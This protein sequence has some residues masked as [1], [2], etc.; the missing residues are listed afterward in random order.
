VLGGPSAA[1][2]ND[3]PDVTAKFDVKLL[4]EGGEGTINV[5]AGR[6]IELTAIDDDQDASLTIGQVVSTAGNTSIRADD[7]ILAASASTSFIQGQRVTLVAADGD[8]RGGTAGSSQALRVNSDVLNKGDKGTGGFN[9]I[10]GGSIDVVET[11]GDLR[12]VK[13]GGLVAAPSVV[14]T[15]TVRLTTLAGS[16]LDANKEGTQLVAAGDTLTKAQQYAY[17]KL[18][19]IA[20]IDYV[21]TKDKVGNVIKTAVYDTDPT[22]NVTLASFQFPVAPGLYK[23]LF[24][25]A[26]FVG[27]TP[28]SGV[29]ETMNVIGSKVT[30]VADGGGQ[31]GRGLSPQVVDMTSGF[32]GLSEA[33]KQLLST[34]TVADVYGVQHALYRYVGTGDAGTNLVSKNFASADWQKISYITTGANRDAPVLRSVANGGYVLAEF[35]NG[36]YGLYKFLGSAGTLDLVA[37]NFGN[38][39]RW[40]KVAAQRQTDDTATSALT[41]GTLVLN[42]NVVERIGLQLQDDVD[43]TS[44]QGVILE[45]DGNVSVQTP[46]TMQVERVRAAGSVYLRAGNGIT[47]VGTQPGSAVATF[48]DLVL[49]AD[50][51]SIGGLAKAPMRIQVGAGG[52]LF[53]SA[54]GDIE[55]R[56]VSGTV[57]INSVTKSIGSLYVD[58]VNAGGTLG[59]VVDSGDMTVERADAKLGARLVATTG[60]IKDAFLDDAAPLVN[61]ASGDLYLEAGTTI[62]EA[63]NFLDVQ[64]AGDLSGKAGGSVYINS[65]STLNITTLESKGGDVTLTVQAQTNIGLIQAHLGTV[66]ITSKDAISDRYDE[67]D[68]DIEARSVVLDSQAGTIGTVDNPLDINTSFTGVLGTVN[69]VALSTV[70]LIETAGV[71]R[72]A[73]VSSKTDDVTLQARSGDI[74]DA[75]ADLITNVTARTVNLLAAGG[76]IGATKDALEVDSS[77]PSQGV[78]NAT[79]TQSINVTELGGTLYVGTVKA[80]AGDVILSVRD[81][82]GTGEDLV[83]DSTASISAPAGS[84]F[85]RVG[86]NVQMAE[87]ATITAAAQ[88]EVRTDADDRAAADADVGKGTVSAYYGHLAAKDIFVYGRDDKDD[89]LFTPQSLAGWTR[90]YGGGANDVFTLEQLPTLDVTDKTNGAGPTGLVTGRIG[91]QR[92]TV[93]IDGQSGEDRTTIITSGNTDY[94]VNVRDTGAPNDGADR[95]TIEGGAGNDVFLS[96]RDFVARLQPN[97]FDASGVPTGYKD[98]YERINY[99]ESINGRLTIEGLGGNDRFHADDNGALMTLDGGAGDDY[100]QF[101]QVFG[102]PRVS[103]AILHPDTG[104]PVQPRVAVGDEIDT[105][106]TTLGMLSRGISFPTVVYGGDG[107]DEFVVYSN[108]ALLK[109]FG[110]DGNDEFVV[111]AFI[112]EG[113]DDLASTDTEVS[114]GA[115]DDTVQYNINAPLSID[116]GAGADTV[117]I[118]GTEA[119]D[120][121]V[122]TKDGVQGAGLNVT[123]TLVEKL[124]VDGMEG[125]DHFFV[126][127]TNQN[128]V[129]TIIGGL[130]S[131]TFDIAGDI[132]QDI[133]AL[134]VEGRSAFINHSV[135]SNDPAF[136]GIY[137]EGVSLNVASGATGAVMIDQGNGLLVVEDGANIDSYVARLAAP[138]PGGSTVLYVTVSGAMASSKDRGAGGRSVQVSLTGNADDFHDALVMTFDA[139]KSGSDPFAWG[140]DQ[141]VYV[142]ASTDVAQE[143]ERTVVISHSSFSANQAFDNL[144]IANVEVRVVDDDKPSVFITETGVSTDVVEDIASASDTYTVVLT[145]QPAAGETVTI[146]V[147]IIGTAEVTTSTSELTFTHDNWNTAQ[148]VTVSGAHDTRAENTLQ[149][150][151]RH[152]ITSGG[153]VYT[154]AIGEQFDVEAKVRDNDAGGVIVTP[155]NGTTVVAEGITDSYTLQLTRQPTHDVVVSIL[156][157]GKSVVSA[158]N[159]PLGRYH[160]VG[161]VPT[162]TFTTANWNVPFEVQVAVNPLAAAESG[163][164]VQSFPAQP[165]TT[166]QINGPLIIEGSPI[167]GKDRSI[168]PALMLPTELDSPLPVLAIEVDE[169]QQTDTLNV[170]NDG[171]V[172]DD[173]GSHGLHH[174]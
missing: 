130:G 60:A 90:I 143:G 128:L 93:D 147:S 164:P 116:G 2:F 17:D 94:I 114:G 153:P 14:A 25:H 172:S 171:S 19:G 55:L 121:F 21:Y 112:I 98:S 34:A 102:D 20:P 155:S 139:A 108:K 61:V 81:T 142:R 122:I 78:L 62:G 123:F 83:L 138:N 24:P 120:S 79:A 165:H 71:M 126:Q 33:S 1:I 7:G 105:V 80:S 103:G 161:G 132:T 87:G 18:N 89:I 133:V 48:G 170:F 73:K 85:L 96:R 4:V 110:D 77:N 30:L 144:N 22:N 135:E 50:N 118:I 49:T 136:D 76:S 173:I 106:N 35:N 64:V 157:D 27:A 101:G 8:I 95:L 150:T 131:D 159:D 42:K 92:D 149:R 86:D 59:I 140:R 67:D 91:G 6:D 166:A 107:E 13:P 162:V 127:S 111:R 63:G 113:T 57:T 9:A 160:V 119:N 163:Q 146:S 124:E 53:A 145:K 115:G 104:L 125:D 66:K 45:S 12:L 97:A 11:V 39:F 167:P 29:S 74:L 10:A 16:I 156:T 58:N 141:R 70:Y 31:I 84:V 41:N 69:A 37:E 36:R 40:E 75:D 3:A 65:P 54:P 129:T 5:Q 47:D 82:A 26:S 154:S 100:F 174:G 44:T 109:L 158:A 168:K 151:I 28:P 169:T 99:D 68:A 152:T 56:Q 72:V 117:V 32:A 15:G 52:H 88:I 134:S 46:G 38:Q 23:F 43:V 148:T 137:A 51:G